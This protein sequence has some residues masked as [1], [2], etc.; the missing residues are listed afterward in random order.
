MR[1][2][3]P[4]TEA[5]ARPRRPASGF[6]CPECSGAL[7]ELREGELAALP[8]PRR[9]R[10]L[11]GGDGRGPGQRRRGRAVDGAR[12][13]RG[14]QRAA[15][16]DRR[17]DGTTSRGPSTAS[18]TGA[19]EADE[20][21]AV[22]RRV[23]ARSMHGGRRRMSD[24]DDAAFEALLEFLKRTRGLDFTGYKRTS[25]QRR[26]RRRMDDRRLR[27]LRRLPRLP[28]GPPRR[29][30]AALRD[31]A[32]QRHRVL[33]RPAGLGAPARRGAAA[34]CSRAKAPD[35]PVRVWSAGCASGQE[36]Y[37]CAMVLAELLGVDALPRAREDLRH[38]HRR[39]RAQPG[40]AGD[41]HRQGDRVGPGRAARALLRARRPAAAR[42]ARTCAAR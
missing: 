36:A 23:L 16:A 20:R 11:R 13:A 2:R 12:G 35:E 19:R 39:G 21:A 6:T 41:L 8:L 37:T 10:L 30:R 5:P 32:D 26:F 14:A 34:R 9:P 27:V 24:A 18:A 33:P 15:A 22:I 31:A 4:A 3:D 1:R 42:S 7:W 25:L 17:P 40:A 28:R 38:R 29:V